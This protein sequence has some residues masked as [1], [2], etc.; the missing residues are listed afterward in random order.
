MDWLYLVGR[1]LFAMIF[2]GSAL[3]HFTQA[4]AMAQYARSKAVPAPKAMV[5]LSG[6]M[7]LGGG[8]SVLLGLWMEIGTWLLFFFLLPA[9]FK[10][11]NFWAL[12]DP[13]QKQTEQAHFMKNLSMAGATLILYWMVQA[14]ESYGPFTLGG[15]M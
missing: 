12:A 6:L 2:I 7:L 8:L 14:L 13:M 10:M 3:G 9:A 5:L 4:N 15:P 11:H 1:I